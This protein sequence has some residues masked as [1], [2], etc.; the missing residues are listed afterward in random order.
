[1]SKVL[2]TGGAGF[3]GS[4]VVDG[5]LRE[6]WEVI[7]VDNLS[8][9][10][11]EQI[12]PRAKFYNLSI[13]DRKMEE[14]FKKEK[15]DL[16]NHHAAQINVRASV[17]DPLF[18]AEQNILG[19]LNLLQNC[20]KFGVK[21]FIFISSGGAIYGEPS[22]LPVK[23]ISPKFP[24]SPYGISKFV[25]EL[26]LYFYKKVFGL[27]YVCL[28][29]ANIYGPRQDPFGE[30]GV[31]AIFSRKMLE[32]KVPTIFGDGKQTR[33]YVFVADVVEANLLATSRLEELNQRDVF[34]VDDLAYNI[35][36]GK[37]VSVNSLYQKL[38]HLTGFKKAPS[39]SQPR[40]GEVKRICLDFSKTEKELGWRPKISLEEGL[41]KTVEWMNKKSS[42]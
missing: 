32:G 5:Y 2:V 24:L 39:F 21:N 20:V 42:L 4:H 25:V 33:D 38:A 17:E 34:S 13:T 23:E 37:E 9:G 41:K 8:T 11:K 36:A 29:Y 27:N 28:R 30:A 19:S 10:K 26:Y 40:E 31:V 7:V 16:V 3:I 6:G 18:D 1:M 15:V 14:I 35:G 12:S 22:E